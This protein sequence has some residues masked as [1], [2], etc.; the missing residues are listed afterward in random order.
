MR[1]PYT[2]GPLCV[3]EKSEHQLPSSRH[4]D[5]ARMRRAVAGSPSRPL[6]SGHRVTTRTS[7]CHPRARA[8]WAV[9]RRRARRKGNR[10]GRTRMP[11]VRPPRARTAACAVGT[12]RREGLAHDLDARRHS[13]ARL[14]VSSIRLSMPKPRSAT[15]PAA[16]P[17]ATAASASRLLIVVPRS[18]G[19]PIGRH[20][21]SILRKL[22]DHTIIDAELLVF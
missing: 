21:A 3:G 9:R 6:S 12:R 16:R 7:A 11:A 8:G 14:A 15:L 2:S 22:Y 1:S 10:R 5:R 19:S 17:A 20:D 4:P 18:E 13:P